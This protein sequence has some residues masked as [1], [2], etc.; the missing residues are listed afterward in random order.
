M[1][2][3]FTNSFVLK[4]NDVVEIILNNDDDGKHPF[5]LHGHIFQVVVRAE[6]EAGPYEQPSYTSAY[7]ASKSLPSVPM[8]RDTLM[9]RPNSHFVVRF[10]AN[11]PGVW[12]FHCHLEWHV[13]SGL[14]AT[15]IESPL[16]LQ[17]QYLPDGL[18]QDH[19][20]V[21]HDTKTPVAGNAAGNIRDALDLT[22][23]NKSPDPL[24]EGFTAKGYVALA[25]SCF[26]AVA[27]MAF[28]GWYGSSTV[29]KDNPA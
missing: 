19:L 28:I 17:Q 3:D 1:Y 27:G 18:P 23:Q 29:K 4:K 8:K 22:G 11:N 6:E 9:V 20:Q 16:D 21:C 2:G 15:L 14:I 25:I 10:R 24:P 26:S 12:L 13:I 5:H 7:E